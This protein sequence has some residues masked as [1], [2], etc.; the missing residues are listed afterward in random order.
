MQNFP[1]EV[2]FTRETKNTDTR[3]DHFVFEHWR[4]SSGCLGGLE[5]SVH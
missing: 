4:V 1:K 5:Q 3:T 2:F